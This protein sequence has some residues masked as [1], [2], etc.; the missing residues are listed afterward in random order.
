M[1]EH[2]WVSA[3]KRSP[4][5]FQKVLIWLRVGNRSPIYGIAYQVEGIWYGEAYGHD[6]EVL[7]WAPLPEPY[8]KMEEDATECLYPKLTLNVAAMH[9]SEDVIQKIIDERIEAHAVREEKIYD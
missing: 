7:A 6:R 8:E 2:R 5:D 9:P 4:E 1:S 3:E